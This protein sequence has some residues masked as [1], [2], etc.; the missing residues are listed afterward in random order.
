MLFGCA[1]P[2]PTQINSKARLTGL[3]KINKINAKMFTSFF[4]PELD[5]YDNKKYPQN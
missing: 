5:S 1:V 3:K 4:L 2:T